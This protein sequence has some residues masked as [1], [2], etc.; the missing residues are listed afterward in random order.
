VS[1]NKIRSLNLS[2]DAT[3]C[4]SYSQHYDVMHYTGEGE[5]TALFNTDVKDFLIRVLKYSYDNEFGVWENDPHPDEL[6]THRSGCASQ[7]INDWTQMKEFEGVWPEHPED[8]DADWANDP[9]SEEFI[10]A[11]TIYNDE[12][13]ALMENAWTE[14]LEEYQEYWL[15]L[16]ISI[17]HYDHK[18]GCA[19]VQSDIWMKASDYVTHGPFGEQSVSVETEMGTLSMAS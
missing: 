16:D 11:L 9:E 1:I 19:T 6:E 15:P 4:I 14:I 5:S 17:E 18:R 10:E 12:V 8:A 7:A 3:V 2:D 13:N